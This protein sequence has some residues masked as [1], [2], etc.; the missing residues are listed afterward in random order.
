MLNKLEY[1]VNNSIISCSLEYIFEEYKL[2]REEE[3]LVLVTQ[4]RIA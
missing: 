3:V 2:I 1:Y 4:L